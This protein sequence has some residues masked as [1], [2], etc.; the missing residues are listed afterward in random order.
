MANSIYLKEY[1]KVIK[2]LKKARQESGLKQI[3]VAEKLGKPQSYISKIEQG[4]RR[5]D[6]VE[7]KEIADVYKKSIEYFIK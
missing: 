4:E 5:I 6:V 1:K 2:R 7:L 3:E